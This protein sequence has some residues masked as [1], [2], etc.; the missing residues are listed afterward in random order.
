[1][2]SFELHSAFYNQPIRLSEEEKTDPLETLREFFQECPLSTVRRTLSHMVETSLS[3]PHSVY[4]DA[5]ERRYMLW[6]YRQMERALEA[7]W[8]L[9][10]GEENEAGKA[11]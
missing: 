1:M 11:G 3:L 10:N 8:L 4:D 2:T 6:L 5:G 7:G 9:C